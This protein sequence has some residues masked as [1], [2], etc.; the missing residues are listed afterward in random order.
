M[1][2]AIY[3]RVST[4]EQTE[5]GHSLTEQERKLKQFCD[6]N[7]WEIH[8]IYT[9]PGFSGSNTNRPG[10]KEM[11][12]ELNRF[13]L[14]LV[15][16][17]DR[18]TRNVRDLL[19]LIDTLEENNVAFRSATEVYDT[20]NSMGRLFVTLVGAIA[21]WERSTISERTLMGR[22]SRAKEG[23]T[24]T[25]LPFFLDKVDGKVVVNENRELARFIIDELLSGKSINNVVETLNNSKYPSPG[26]YR[27]S[28]NRSFNN[29]RWYPSSVSD[30]IHNAHTRGHIQYDDIF[31]RDAH[32]AIMTEKE[33]KEITKRIKK[34]LNVTTQ[35]HLAVF[36]KR[37][38][39]PVCNATLSV[40]SSKNSRGETFLYYACKDCKLEKRPSISFS[41][42][43][44]MKSFYEKIKTYDWDEYENNVTV[45]KRR[46][47]IDID[48][49]MSKRKKYHELYAMD[50]MDKDELSEFMKESD[51]LIAEY[52]ESR[53]IQDDFNG[54]EFENNKNIILDNWNN[55]SREEL[56]ELINLTVDRIYI[57]LEKVKGKNNKVD[58]TSI[59]W[60]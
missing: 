9:D 10:L 30:M 42:N 33:Y 23:K 36:R 22:R 31:I 46:N 56:A 34:R 47:I 38:E 7:D 15:Y 6:M 8:K 26:K 29:K 16:K 12:N 40:N 1:K 3:T 58:V 45:K 24:M 44:I 2:I 43:T 20:S 4:L 48:K 55:L 51:K 27:P 50:L 25:K 5:K 19:T 28:K 21:E 53:L 59:V 49:V 60:L 18:L 57:N 35:K 11:L 13:D 32:E 41:E 54:V 37:I 14:V 17:L 39:C 52:E